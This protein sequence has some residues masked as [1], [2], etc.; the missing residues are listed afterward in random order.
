[1]LCFLDLETTGLDPC[2]DRILEVGM[3]LTDWQ[4]NEVDRHGVLLRCDPD[5]LASMEP[6]V[7]VMHKGLLDDIEQRGVHPR[8]AYAGCMDFLAKHCPKGAVPAAGF[9]PGFDRGFLAVHCWPMHT[10]L[11]HRSLDVST[12]KMLREHLRPD[13]PEPPKGGKAHRALPDC[14]E[15]I[16][17]LRHFYSHWL[18]PVRS[19]VESPP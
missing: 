12:L 7:R 1:M 18:T 15:A 17:A 9:T 8:E 2:F 13:V 11:N 6:A 14:E 4:L 5:K 3:I 19:G 10:W 16:K